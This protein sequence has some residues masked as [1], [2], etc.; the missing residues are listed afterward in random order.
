ML[1]LLLRP[2]RF[3]ARALTD[4]TTPGQ[5]AMGFA[6]GMVAG[7]VPK[8]NLLAVVLMMMVCGSRVNLGTA[9]L[10]MFLFSWVGVLLDPVSHELGMWLL[11]RDSLAG[12]WTALYNLP[13]LPWSK[14]N[15]SVVLGSFLLG[16]AMLYPVYRLSQPRFA[17]WQPNLAERFRKFRLA[18]LLLGAECAGKLGGA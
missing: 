1:V 6:L 14:F 3:L 4:Q 10:G 7:L 13:I 11:T 15:N 9:M 5:L 2:I 16:L 8:G 18:K 12:F 17:V